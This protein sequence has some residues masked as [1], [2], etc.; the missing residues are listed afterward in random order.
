MKIVVKIG[1]AAARDRGGGLLQSGVQKER[2]RAGQYPA[3]LLVRVLLQEK[4][5]DAAWA[6]VRGFLALLR[7][8]TLR[9]FAWYRI[10]VAPVIYWLVR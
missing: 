9:P 5:F 4:M 2:L 8:H 10:A 3:D 1:G 6:A 7:R